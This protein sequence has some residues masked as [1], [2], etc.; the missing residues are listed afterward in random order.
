VAAVPHLAELQSRLGGKR[1]TV[2]GIASEQGPPAARAATVSK[3]VRKL[4]INYP[5][6]LSGMDGESCPVQEALHIQ[7]FPTLILVD[8]QGRILWRDQGATPATLA[9]L[10]H[11]IASATKSDDTR[12]Y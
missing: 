9:K 6:L 12:R 2:L 8:R 10:D 5:V 7:A 1:L 11:F 4:G 3:A